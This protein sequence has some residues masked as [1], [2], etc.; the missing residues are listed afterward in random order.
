M[1]GVLLGL[2]GFALVVQ[3]RG[4]SADEQLAT[5]R[6][7]DL[8]RIL[9]DLDAREERLQQEISDLEDSRR[10]LQSGAQGPEA[11]LAAIKK[12]ADELGI[13][14]GTL[15][16]QGPGLTIVFT[17]QGDAIKAATIL[18]AVEELRGAGAEAMQI[19]GNQGETVRVIASTYFADQGGSVVVD[20]VALAG[21]YTIE[22]IG[23][24]QTMRTA[25]NIP[26]GVV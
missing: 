26:G 5:A 25:M 16:A 4:N 8:V 21:P 12:R 1:I 13:L 11:A 19:H 18:D 2:L 20:G 22:V 7:D 15:A 9:S 14:A 24:P 23:D 10:Q 6:Q 17:A 3:L